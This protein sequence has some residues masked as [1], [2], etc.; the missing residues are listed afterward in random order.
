VVGT[1][2]QRDI[3]QGA[4]PDAAPTVDLKAPGDL[5][6]AQDCA[7][8]EPNTPW[9][10]AKSSPQSF[11]DKLGQIAK[12]AHANDVILG[13]AIFGFSVKHKEAQELSPRF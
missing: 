5:G 3:I 2:R 7:S 9:S 11:Y 1:H 6:Q 8:D 12:R 13:I 4:L 10:M